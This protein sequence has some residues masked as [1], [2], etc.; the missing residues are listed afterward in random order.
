MGTSPQMDDLKDEGLVSTNLERFATGK[1]LGTQNVPRKSSLETNYIDKK[2]IESVSAKFEESASKSNQAQQNIIN[3]VPRKL[4]DAEKLFQHNKEDYTDCVRV[5]V[6]V[7]KIDA[8]NIFKP[9]L[10]DTE[11]P[12]D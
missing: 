10:Q 1:I 5:E 3:H 6:K 8:E 9:N 11:S 4:K 7:G 12:K 2:H